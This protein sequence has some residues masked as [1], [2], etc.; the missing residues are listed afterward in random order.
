[1]NNRNFVI[2][3]RPSQLPPAV[4]FYIFFSSSSSL[5]FFSFLHD[6]YDKCRYQ[7]AAH[8]QLP[9]GEF[10]NGYHTPDV[11]WSSR[12]KNLS[13]GERR[14]FLFLR[15]VRFL[16]PLVFQFNISS[17]NSAQK[18]GGRLYD[19]AHNSRIREEKR[20]DSGQVGKLPPTDLHFLESWED[21]RRTLE[22][23]SVHNFSRALVN[24]K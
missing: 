15:F 6:D 12:G 20:K 17:R 19:L 8:S 18:A 9:F 5:L 10:T 1:M 2:R 24:R 21:E 13:L 11:R 4:Q 3:M 7:Y 16:R 14:M 22:R 23:E